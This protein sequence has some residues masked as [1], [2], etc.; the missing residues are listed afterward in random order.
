MFRNM[1]SISLFLS[2]LV[3]LNL[4]GQNSFLKTYGG[5]GQDEGRSISLSLDGG[6]II[7]GYTSSNDGFFKGNN[8]GGNDIFIVKYN[9]EGDEVWK[10]NY[11]GWKHDY[12][13][14]IITTS[15]SGCI[16]TGTTFSNDGDFG[17][18]N[19]GGQD[20]FV[21]KL[22]K[23]G[24]LEWKK[25]YGGSK[26]DIGTSIV[27]DGKDY[28]VTGNSMSNDGDFNSNKGSNDIF[29]LKIDSKGQ[30]VWVRNYGGSGDDVSTS[31]C[32]SDD[33]CYVLT[34]NTISNDGDFKEMGISSN[35]IF[36]MKINSN[37][38]ILWKNTYGGSKN[39]GGKCVKSTFDKGYILTGYTYSNDN[40]FRDMNKDWTDMFVI[41]IDSIGKIVWKKTFGGTQ[42][43][44][45]YSVLVTNDNEVIVV[46][47]TNSVNGD[48]T[49]LNHSWTYFD[50]II[51]KLNNDGDLIWKRGY[52]GSWNEIGMS[53]VYTPSDEIV[54]V[55]GSDSNDGDLKGLNKGYGDI[56]LL[57]LDSNGNLN[58]TTSINE[59]SEPTTTL[60]VHPNPF[61]NTTTVSY[62]VETPSNISIELLN[63]LGQ[64]IE[65]LRNDYSDSGTYQLP[66]NVS[67]LTS[68]MYSVRMR[69]GSSSI[70]VPVWVIR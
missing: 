27:Y 1:I 12:G 70:V 33:K 19:K 62:K 52:G 29:L 4:S 28:L 53:V 54:V 11:G 8:K 56:V 20:I 38:G 35:D 5:G 51:L 26:D 68:G 42:D 16:L 22:D 50:V 58:N 59:F 66:L 43:D 46:G 63:I 55:G 18:L 3:T 48:F 21:I 69:S 36:S 23:N 60:S 64:T 47:H 9:K 41:K 67:N 17:G 7:T 2:V 14:S 32:V 25:I 61:S 65:V 44:V 45:S 24:N 15:D 40:D 13:N 49:G 30:I 37:G 6:Y 34:G 39:D 57:K 10:Y 31:V